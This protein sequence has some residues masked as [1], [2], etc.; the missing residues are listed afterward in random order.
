MAAGG[1]PPKVMIADKGY[2]SDRAR[3]SLESAGTAAVIPMRK[4]R[5]VQESIDGFIYAMLNRI[6]RCFNKLKNFRRLATRY[7]K[8]AD[9]YLG[10]VQI[11]AIHLWTR[12]FVNRTQSGVQPAQRQG[13]LRLS[14]SNAE[15]TDRVVI[16]EVTSYPNDKFLNQLNCILFILIDVC[17]KSALVFL[18]KNP[19]CWQ[20]SDGAT[21]ASRSF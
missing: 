13:A 15:Y 2:D 14:Y 1:P 10:F 17:K 20:N 7:D 5:K 8:T 11:A 9:S 12:Q 19:K 16:N 4:N 3:A 18:N 6:E 21:S